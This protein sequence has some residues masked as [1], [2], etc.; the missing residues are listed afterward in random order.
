M[1]V[2]V[3]EAFTLK[4]CEHPFEVWRIYFA[5]YLFSYLPNISAW[6]RLWFFFA[7]FVKKINKNESTEILLFRDNEA[8]MWGSRVVAFTLRVPSSF[9][10]CSTHLGFSPQTPRPAQRSSCSTGGH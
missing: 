8:A 3:C 4:I 1:C 5:S 2:C 6:Q 9:Q 10:V 7:H